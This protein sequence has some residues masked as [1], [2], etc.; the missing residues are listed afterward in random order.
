MYFNNIIYQTNDTTKMSLKYLSQ[1]M[2]NI[3]SS[4]HCVG[5]NNQYETTANNHGCKWKRGIWL[6]NNNII[7]NNCSFNISKTGMCT[8][9]Y[10]LQKDNK[11]WTQ[12]NENEKQ[13][14]TITNENL[15]NEQLLTKCD[16]QLND[17]RDLKQKHQRLNEKILECNTFGIN[18]LE[19]NE[20]LVDIIQHSA[21][22]CCFF[23]RN[24]LIF[25][26][27]FKMILLMHES[28]QYLG[29]TF[30]LTSQN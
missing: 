4:S 30:F 29:H 2:N 14:P 23:E 26:Q 25:C 28:Q 6:P 17:I 15:T 9:C 13:R 10:D 27:F 8:N 20:F 22:F 5:F 18:N 1:Q 24:L 12:L 19:T 16:N 7:S 21:I 11:E 3:F